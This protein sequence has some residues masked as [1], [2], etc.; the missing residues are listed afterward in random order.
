MRRS[1]LVQVDTDRVTKEAKKVT[2]TATR[3]ARAYYLVSHLKVL[4]FYFYN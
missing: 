1:K 3:S 4:F 2:H